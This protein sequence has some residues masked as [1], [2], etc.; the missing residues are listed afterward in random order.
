MANYAL[1]RY[2]TAEQDTVDAALELLETRLETIDTAKV[3]RMYGVVFL[4][5]DKQRCVGYVAYDT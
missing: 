4:G 1:T 5:R 2:V 3:I